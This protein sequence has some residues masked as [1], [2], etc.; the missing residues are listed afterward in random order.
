MELFD[1]HFHYSA[2]ECAEKYAERAR[3]AD[4]R[5]L[6]AVGTD[7]EESKTAG[8]FASNVKGAWFSAGVHPHESSRYTGDI[9]M[10][11]EFTD[12]SNMIAVG[13][14]GLDYYYQNSDKTSQRKVFEFFLDFALKFDFP[15]IVHCRDKDGSESVY[16]DAYSLLAD[17]AR[18]GGTF[19]LHC[20]TGTPN[21]CEKFLDLGAFLGITG[22]VTFPK[23][24]NIRE[25]LRI[26][27][28]RRL[29]L[30]TDSP[31]LAPMPY[32]GH[33]NHPEYLLEIARQVAV[34]KV[35]ALE[36][37][38]ELTTSNAFEFFRIK[39]QGG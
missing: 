37:T 23:A 18:S 9:S 1:T 32:R 22:I 12:D 16:V 35:L 10:F 7:Y 27:P 13:E 21:W 8:K 38:V 30:E 14:I 15:A 26:I 39:R 17:F 19:V 3:K 2:C 29:L 33:K 6:I 24:K 28:D 31:Y 25:V 20:Y 34:E 36:E 4:V 5:Y 11:T